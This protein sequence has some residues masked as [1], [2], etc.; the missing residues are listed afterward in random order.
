MQLEEGVHSIEAY[1][2]VHAISDPGLS[3][4]PTLATNYWLPRPPLRST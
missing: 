1:R 4:I 2:S 3:L